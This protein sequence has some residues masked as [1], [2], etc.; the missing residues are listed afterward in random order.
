MLTKK[1]SGLEDVINDGVVKFEKITED[2]NVILLIT[3]SKNGLFFALDNDFDSVD[4]ISLGDYSYSTQEKLVELGIFTKEDNNLIEELESFTNTYLPDLSV[5][6][7]INLRNL[8]NRAIVSKGGYRSL[9]SFFDEL[10]KSNCFICPEDDNTWSATPLK[11]DMDDGCVGWGS[12]PE[13]AL[14][15]AKKFCA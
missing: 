2:N 3:V 10:R 9:G 8:I 7:L 5:D 11:T 14:E 13:E 6:E 15:N 4:E 1:C 12:T